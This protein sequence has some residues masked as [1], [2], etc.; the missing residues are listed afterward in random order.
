LNPKVQV[1]SLIACR[2]YESLREVQLTPIGRAPIHADIKN[3]LSE[4]LGDAIVVIV[5]EDNL[6]LATF[7]LPLKAEFS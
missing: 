1:P 2:L 3:L 6:K 4:V 7:C 5:S